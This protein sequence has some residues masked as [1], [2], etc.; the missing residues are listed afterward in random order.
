[1]LL[2][3]ILESSRYLI[4]VPV[5][6]SLVGAF[7]LLA[8]GALELIG[9][10]A[11]TFRYGIFDEKV[12][13]LLAVAFTQLIDS[14]LLGTVLY[15]IAIGLYELFIDPHIK[16]P[17]WLEIRTL[18]DLKER[19][20]GTVAVMLVVTFLGYFVTWGGTAS[21]LWA[22]AAV[23]AVLLALAYFLRHTISRRGNPE[24]ARSDPDDRAQRLEDISM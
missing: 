19:L 8:F 14:F 4:L 24:R 5:I 13:K 7:L 16:T 11:T 6:G 23:A 3:R 18:D 2:G 1:M 15:I 9:I 21:I 10:V 22:G 12:A 17:A 20:L